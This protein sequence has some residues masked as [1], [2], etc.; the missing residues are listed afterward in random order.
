MERSSQAGYV[1]IAGRG[2]SGSTLLELLLGGHPDLV[3]MGEVEKLGLQFAR[4]ED[5]RYPGLCSCGQRP[6]ACPI[7][8]AVAAAI[9]ERHGADLTKDPFSFRLSDVGREEDDGVRAFGDWLVRR[10]SRVSRYLAYAR[11]PAWRH[12]SF[13]S[14]HRRWAA[15]RLF[16]GDVVRRLSQAKAAVDASKDQ[17]GMRDVY[18]AGGGLARII[19]ITRDVRGSVWSQVKRGGATVEQAARDWTQV[20]G[21]IMRL[22]ADVPRADWVHLKY[23]D[24]CHDLSG[25]LERL[26]RFLGYAYDPAM[27]QLDRKE[28]HTIGGNQIRFKAIEGVREDLSWKEKLSADDVSRIER[29]A[30]PVTEPL[31]L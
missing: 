1:Y 14:S 12:L 22:L 15:N 23:E 21:A 19:F 7:W 17:L 27:T 8:A 25:T 30:R 28:R 9:K 2:H 10:L 18:E 4:K 26:C 3:A 29:I 20:N 13:S 16:V 5:A 11:T 31:G 6:Q 24:L